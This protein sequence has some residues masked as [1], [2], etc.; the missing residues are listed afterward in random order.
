MNGAR[1]P[2]Q[3]SA[4]PPVY[5]R[6]RKHQALTTGSPKSKLVQENIAGELR[7]AAALIQAKRFTDARRVL[8][9]VL[10][11]DPQNASALI[12]LAASL[13]A[14]GDHP[15]AVAAAKNAAGIAPQAPNAHYQLGVALLG[16]KRARDAQRA[17]EEAVSLSPSRA[18][19]HLALASALNAQR[20]TAHAFEETERAI[21][22]NPNS[23]DAWGF[24]GLL[25]SGL[26]K[27]EEAE[28]AA[29]RAL[30]LA[31]NSVA[32]H[33]ADGFAAF[34]ALRAADAV[35]AFREVLRL[36]P[37][38]VQARAGYAASARLA[39]PV[40]RSLTVKSTKAKRLRAIALLLVVV[41][42]FVL[43][44]N[45]VAAVG[46][47]FALLVFVF[48]ALYLIG[49]VVIHRDR[50]IRHILRPEEYVPAYWFFGNAIAAIVFAVAGLLFRN[51]GLGWIAATCGV[52]AFATAIYAIP[53]ALPDAAPASYRVQRLIAWFGLFMTAVT[54]SLGIAYGIAL[55]AASR[56]GRAAFLI[57]GLLFT[58]A[59]IAALTLG[60]FIA[61]SV[62]FKL[63]RSAKR[64]AVKRAIHA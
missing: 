49:T 58:M 63:A 32:A 34:T 41:L 8:T 42:L 15:N 14:L 6:F 9:D 23:A 11:R 25:L 10:G 54:Q 21:A 27:K 28:Q 4:I 64:S 24:K 56:P 61:T 26:G 53:A 45:P 37:A 51:I 29:A 18:D 48:F 57:L 46:Y 30:A 19:F 55:G 40:F 2:R 39:L 1:S 47:G 44:G 59:V 12:L 22:L 5:A 13:T 43:T 20:A 38:N 3:V 35:D 60:L 36:D 62:L 7:G 16:G 52:A 33:L 31:P 50:L 17:F